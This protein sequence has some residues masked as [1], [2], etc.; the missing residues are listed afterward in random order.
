[1][2]SIVNV[3]KFSTRQGQNSS[4]IEINTLHKGPVTWYDLTDCFSHIP[5][6]YW[7]T[8]IAV[9]PKENKEDSLFHAIAMACFS[10]YTTGVMR[11]ERINREKI[12]SDLR[13]EM[14]QRL[15]DDINIGSSQVFDLLNGGFPMPVTYDE[16]YAQFI[17]TAPP[18]IFML[19]HISNCI[20]RDIYLYDHEMRDIWVLGNE[21]YRIKNRPSIVL[22]HNNG[23]YDVIGICKSDESVFMH[24]SPEHE[25]ILFIQLTLQKIIQK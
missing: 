12:V 17:G 2:N 7:R 14:A 10:P 15:S 3:E 20:G 23:C 4:R 16:L 25:F 8:M 19:E 5:G 11:G 6:W 24:F 1:M 21:S 18:S 9:T 22:Y 13:L